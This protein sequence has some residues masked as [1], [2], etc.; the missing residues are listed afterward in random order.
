MV[1]GDEQ[2][3][4]KIEIEGIEIEQELAEKPE[5]CIF[6]DSSSS[7]DSD[8]DWYKLEGTRQKRTRIL[9]YVD[10]TVPKYSF[11]EFPQHFRVSTE[12]VEMLTGKY[13]NNVSKNYA[14]GWPEVSHRKAVLIGLWY[15]SNTETYRQISDRFDISL[16]T[17]HQVVAA[18]RKEIFYKDSFLLGDSAYPSLKWL[19]HSIQNIP[20]QE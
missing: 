5:L 14:G 17:A 13:A 4:T 7:S 16:S 19:V 15:L 8:N 10:R 1:M 11:A 3:D 9:N 2:V 6:S 18:E 12:I 20:V